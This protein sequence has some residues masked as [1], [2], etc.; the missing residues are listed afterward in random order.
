LGGCSA[1]SSQK[2]GTTFSKN[3]NIIIFLTNNL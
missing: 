2:G 3:L 1:L